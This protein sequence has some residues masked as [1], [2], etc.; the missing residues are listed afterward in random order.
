MKPNNGYLLKSIAGVPYILPFGQNIADYRRGIR[1]NDTGA[2]IWKLL[3]E[4]NDE[5]SLLKALEDCYSDTGADPSEMAKDLRQFL[6]LLVSFG[7]VTDEGAGGS[8]GENYVKT[9]RIA[10][11]YIDLFGDGAVFSPEFDAFAADRR[12]HADLTVSAR[13]GSP[14][15][16]ENGTVLLRNKELWV[17]DCGEN[18]VFLFPEAKG[19]L[20]ATLKKDGSRAD[21]FL[22]PPVCD[23]LVNDLFHAVRLAFLCLAEKKGMF[24][25]HS[26]SVLYN[27]KA[28]LFSGRSGMGKSTHA[29][30][31]SRLYRAPTANGDL[32]LIGRTDG[33]PCIHGIPWCGTSGLRDTMTHPLGGIVLLGRGGDTV[34]ALS[35]HEKILLVAQRFIS[36]AWTGAQL[37]DSLDFA[38]ALIKQVPVCRLQCTDKPSAAEKMKA[39]IDSLPEG[40]PAGAF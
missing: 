23:T 14:R 19:I 6:D 7:M 22:A 32:N 28:W 4:H 29:A 18:Y 20:Q 34:E 16:A 12:E 38:S 21:F 17:M 40:S 25:L 2:L 39:W 11:L 10:G 35:D 33:V 15:R 36:P 24:A 27:G 37:T 1:V 5:G 9:L 13:F 26:A 8:A 31:W 3:H 30:L